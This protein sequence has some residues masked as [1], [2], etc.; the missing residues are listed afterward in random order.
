MLCRHATRNWGNGLG[1]PFRSRYCRYYRYHLISIFG[2]PQAH[3]SLEGRS[4]FLWSRLIALVALSTS[5]TPVTRLQ[6]IAWMH[7]SPS[8]C[9]TAVA[10]HEVESSHQST[11]PRSVAEGHF[12]LIDTTGLHGDDLIR[13]VPRFSDVVVFIVFRGEARTTVNR[14]TSSILRPTN[15]RILTT[16]ITNRAI[17]RFTKL[18]R[19]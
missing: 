10:D 2:P 3:I 8:H 15:F 14:T 12:I 9:P 1:K 5:V 13:K 18:P 16:R 19:G 11:A 17:S 7:H 4:E 6:A